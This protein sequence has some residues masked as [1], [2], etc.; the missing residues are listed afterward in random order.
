[1]IVTIVI[2]TAIVVLVVF[3]LS[4]ALGWIIAKRRDKVALVSTTHRSTRWSS[5]SV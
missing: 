1:V 5:L 3:T 4:A 2:V